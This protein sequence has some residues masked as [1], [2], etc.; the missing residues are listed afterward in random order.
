MTKL[1]SPL[2]ILR[3]EC[4]KDLFG[5]LD[6]LAKIGYDGV[7]FIGLFGHKPG[8]IRSRLDS[9]G[10]D[11]IGDH[12]PFG[13]F[14]ND[15]EKI[16]ED[17]LTLGCR[18]ITVGSPGPDGMPGSDGYRLTVETLNALGDKTKSAGMRLLYHNHANELRS[19]FNGKTALEY[20]FDDTDP[21][22]LLAE[23]DLGWI[24][25]GGAE[26][27]HFL[28]KYRSRCPVIHLKDF[29]R[30]GEKS[31]FEFRPTGYGEAGYAALC[32]EIKK[33]AIN[34]EWYVLDHDD[35]YGRDIFYDLKI[36]L[37]YV[38]NLSAIDG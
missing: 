30:T 20:F 38:K 31:A 19:R 3:N 24:M 5:V 23:P 13:E 12:V 21:G 34:P 22:L 29:I 27:V 10:I 37:D 26:P 1:G 15:P 4:A 11:A 8:E 17:H 28:R 18:F 7:E 32:A 6:R 25:I 14:A 35:A 36:S 9:L 2:F 33:L 16:I